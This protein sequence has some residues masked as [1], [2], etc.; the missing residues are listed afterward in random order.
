MISNAIAVMPDAPNY[1][2]LLAYRACADRDA[3]IT[4]GQ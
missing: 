1:Q 3:S 4:P 2:G